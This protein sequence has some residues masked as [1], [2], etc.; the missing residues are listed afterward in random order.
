MAKPRNTRKY[1]VRVKG[2]IVHGGKTDRPLEERL[3]EHRLKWPKATI[4]QVGRATTDEAASKWEKE[5]GYS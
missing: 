2:K 4:K 3:Q 1:Q 5:K